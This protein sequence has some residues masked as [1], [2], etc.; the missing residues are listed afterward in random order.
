MAIPRGERAR[1]DIRLAR[2]NAAWL[3]L[4]SPRIRLKRERTTCRRRGAARQLEAEGKKRLIAY[5]RQGL[6][7]SAHDDPP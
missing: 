2:M 6:R 4:V 3:E 5:L 1:F 7:S